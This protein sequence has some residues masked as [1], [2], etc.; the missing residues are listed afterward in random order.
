MCDNMFFQMSHRGKSFATLITKTV[1][2]PMSLL[3]VIL[4]PEVHVE[5]LS[6]KFTCVHFCANSMYDPF[7]RCQFLD[8]VLVCKLLITPFDITDQRNFFV[9]MFYMVTQK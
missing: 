1:F 5:S 7:V 3:F 9:H 2:L 4:K 8:L 6:T